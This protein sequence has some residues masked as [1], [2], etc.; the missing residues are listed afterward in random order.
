MLTLIYRS[1]NKP[2]SKE[3]CLPIRSMFKIASLKAKEVVRCRNK[4]EEF[5][6]RLLSLNKKILF[7]WL[8]W[9]KQRTNPVKP[10]SMIWW[11]PKKNENL[12]KRDGMIRKVPVRQKSKNQRRNQNPNLSQ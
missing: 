3:T 8:F 6:C 1:K 9:S 10:F 7:G 4:Q 2:N 12:R 5:L 11:R